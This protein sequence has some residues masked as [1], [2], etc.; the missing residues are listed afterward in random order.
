MTTDELYRNIKEREQHLKGQVQQT[1][2]ALEG[3][4]ENPTVLALRDYEALNYLRQIIK[5]LKQAIK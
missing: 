5:Q 3:M 1:I 2:D 4:V